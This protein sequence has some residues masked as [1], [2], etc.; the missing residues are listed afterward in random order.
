MTEHVLP[1]SMFEEIQEL[2]KENKQLLKKVERMKCCGNCK[3]ESVWLAKAPCDSCTR[4]APCDPES[5]DNWQ[6]KESI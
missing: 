6:P 4:N 2:K 1:L 3:Y 5:I